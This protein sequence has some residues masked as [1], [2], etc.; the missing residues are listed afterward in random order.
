MLLNIQHISKQFSTEPVLENIC[1]TLNENHT[2]SI[3][4]KS[5]CGKSTLLKIIA[6]VV[7]QDEG[8]II[9]KGTNINTLPANLRHIVYMSQEP[10]LFPHLN[11]FENIAFGLRIKKEKKVVVDTKVNQLLASLGLQSHHKKMPHQLSGGQKQRVNFGRSL[12]INPPLLLLDEP[13]GN[14]D[15]QTRAEMQRL[16]K[17]VAAEFN[18]ASIFVTHDIKEALLMGD[19]IGYMNAGKLKIYDSK[20]SFISD[21]ITGAQ[22]EITFWQ[23]L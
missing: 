2:L 3:L 22:Q 17:Q 18:I 9:L 19:G 23:N 5:G 16:F 6:G 20:K 14:L 8:D 1:L 4:G 21:S 11:V 13:F 7:L 12:I 10:L 15:T